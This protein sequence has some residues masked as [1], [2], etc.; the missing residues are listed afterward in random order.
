MRREVLAEKT[1]KGKEKE[2]EEEKES[3]EKERVLRV[4]DSPAHTPHAEPL[5]QR[6]RCFT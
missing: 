5:R 4:R 2:K 6:T 3:G 1:R